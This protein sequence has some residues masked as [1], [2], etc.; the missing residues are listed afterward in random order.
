MLFNFEM[1]FNTL[2]ILA[3][4]L[5][6]KEIQKGL[7]Y[8]MVRNCSSEAEYIHKLPPVKLDIWSEGTCMSNTKWCTELFLNFVSVKQHLRF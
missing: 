5:K 2:I 6:K 3:L 8:K 7:Y 1:V 4:F